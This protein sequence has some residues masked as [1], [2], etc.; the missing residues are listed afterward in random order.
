LHLQ[1]V[2]PAQAGIPQQQKQTVMKKII[3]T[4]IALFL[5][6]NLSAF[7]FGEQFSFGPRIGFNMTTMTNPGHITAET[8]AINTMMKGG[9]QVGILGDYEFEI[10][11]M[12]FFAQLGLLFNSH[13]T[14]WSHEGFGNE[15]RMTIYSLQLPLSAQYRLELTQDW[16]LVFQLGP[17]MDFALFGREVTQDDGIRHDHIPMT[18]GANNDARRFG[19]G[20]AAGAGIQVRDLQL[21]IGYN[22]GLRSAAHHGMSRPHGLTISATYLFLWNAVFYR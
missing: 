15:T 16:T 21:V 2:I 6:A 19:I 18:F 14:R 22:F 12:P 7:Q 17:V 5:V 20:M 11:G 13:G 9:F 8:N 1:D 3:T 10:S 4:A